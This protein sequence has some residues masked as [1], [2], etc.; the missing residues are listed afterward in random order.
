MAA[1][2]R[3]SEGERGTF[4]QPLI[5]AASTPRIGPGYGVGWQHGEPYPGHQELYCWVCAHHG[6]SCS[7]HSSSCIQPPVLCFTAPVIQSAAPRTRGPLSH[8]HAVPCLTLFSPSPSSVLPFSLQLS[9][10]HG[11]RHIRIT[12]GHSDSVGPGQVWALASFKS[13]QVWEAGPTMPIR[14]LLLVE[15]PLFLIPEPQSHLSSKAFPNHP[16][17]PCLDRA[18]PL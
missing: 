4:P 3:G 6:P 10:S 8:L 18:P 5:E 14:G 7:P 1:P 9:R 2:W 15:L 17:T 13:S 16:S 11:W 12:K